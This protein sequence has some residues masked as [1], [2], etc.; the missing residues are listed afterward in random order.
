MLILGRERKAR[1]ALAADTIVGTVM[2]NV[3]LERA[4]HA[5]G[6]TLRRAA[7]GDRYVLEDM[8]SGGFVLGGEQSGHIIDLARN[9][10]GDGPM[11][12]VSLFSVV[13]ASGSTL[14]DLASALVVFPQVLVNVRVR[15]RAVAHD[16]AV[17]Q[18]T[19]DA[20]AELGDTGR[21]LVRASGTEPLVR[22]MV[23]GPDDATIHRVAERVADVIRLKSSVTETVS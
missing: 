15:D 18:A 10:T 7:V 2:S 21:I 11:T 13:A 19:A 14:H 22:V 16:A 3:G 4:L 12:A 17:A 5:E 23:E 6:I 1:G 9:T 8:R 20:A